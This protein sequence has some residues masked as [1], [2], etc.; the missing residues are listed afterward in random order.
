MYINCPKNQ[1]FG[2]IL[3]HIDPPSLVEKTPL[4]CFGEVYQ[5]KLA[6]YLR[7]F[8]NPEGVKDRSLKI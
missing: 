8:L 4:R 7:I 2:S 6:R 3:E 5:E 1:C